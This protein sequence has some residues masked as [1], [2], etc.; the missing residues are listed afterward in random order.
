MFVTLERLSVRRRSGRLQRLL[1]VLAALALVLGGYLALIPV[2]PLVREVTLSQSSPLF[3]FQTSPFLVPEQVAF[4]FPSTSGT[5]KKPALPLWVTVIDCGD[6]GINL[7][8]PFCNS[9][10]Q[11][12]SGSWGMGVDV[13]RNNASSQVTLSI[14]SQEWIQVFLSLPIDAINNTTVGIATS[15]PTVGVPLLFGGGSLMAVLAVLAIRR[16]RAVTVERAP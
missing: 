13:Y 10:S 16:R 14:S 11:P 3:F 1:T 5:P 15:S 7:T 4:T 8:Q 9:S 12:G 6:S 2:Q